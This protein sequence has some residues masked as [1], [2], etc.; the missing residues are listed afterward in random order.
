MVEKSMDDRLTERSKQTD[1]SKSHIVRKALRAFLT[2]GHE[3]GCP[4][5]ANLER[6]RDENQQLRER[7]S[8]QEAEI[9]E[10]RDEVDR[11]R[12]ENY[13]WSRGATLS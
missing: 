2:G 9:E 7:L 13:T 3:T 11:L 12:E 1:Q 5:K 4:H 10:L 6:A 8:E